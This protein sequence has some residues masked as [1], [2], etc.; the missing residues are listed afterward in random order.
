MI[1]GT[2]IR[3]GR[4]FLYKLI[5]IDMD[6]TLLNDQF[7]ISPEN[8]ATL[9][10]VKEYGAIIAICTG[11]PVNG[12]KQYE[13]LLGGMID[14][15]ISYNGGLI[16][17]LANENY[18]NKSF[19]TYEDVIYLHEISEQVQAPIQFYDENNLYTTSKYMNKYTVMDAYLGQTP[20]HY[21]D[22]AD[23]C[24]EAQYPK[25]QFIDEPDRLTAIIK[26]LPATLYDRYTIMQSEPYFLEFVSKQTN[27]GLALE[28]LAKKLNMKREEII[29]FGNNENDIAMLDFAGCG[30][31]MANATNAVKNIADRETLTNNDHGV[32]YM[33]EKTLQNK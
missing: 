31:A 13:A 26:Q 9:K 16:E 22:R 14:Y 1:D 8:I 28:K 29:A 7:T 15:S 3:K 23:I 20:L 19:L 5:A 6:G 4:F 27:K 2:S 32:A 10:K 30:V 11:R 12:V 17:D 21:I 18:I 33:L 24:K 25:V